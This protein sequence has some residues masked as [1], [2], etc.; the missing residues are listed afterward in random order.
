MA[1]K[2]LFSWSGGKDSSMGLWRIMEGGDYEVEALMTTVTD[3]YNRVSIH[4]VRRELLKAQAESIGLPLLEISLPGKT[5]NEEYEEIMGREMEKARQ[6]G[7]FKVAFS[8]LYLEDVRE[9]R[10][11][12]LARARMKAIFP[13][14]GEDTLAFAHDFIK[15]GFKAVI[16]CVDTRA[17]EASFSGRFFDESFLEDLPEGV[18]PCGENGEFH[19]YVFDGP[20][21]HKSIQIEL[22]E[23]VLRE[24]RFQYIDV[25]AA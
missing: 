8:D 15:S 10:E 13:V 3:A 25:L 6:R 20:I 16:T 22:G 14:W 24:Q 4:G 18:D 11:K 23:R 5:S 2:I 9:Y 7:V 1:E 17:L 12:N 21:F 19:S